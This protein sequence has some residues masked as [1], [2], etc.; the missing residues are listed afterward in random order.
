MQEEAQKSQQKMMNRIR[1]RGKV[2]EVQGTF[3]SWDHTFQKFLLEIKR[4]SGTSDIIPVVCKDDVSWMV[5]PGKE[6][7]VEGSVRTRNVAEGEHNKLE[8]TVFGFVSL[9]EPDEGVEEGALTDFNEVELDGFICK[10]VVLRETPFKKQIADIFIAVNGQANRSYY[11]PCVAFFNEAR[12]AS[13]LAVGQK[14][15]VKGRLQSRIYN[16]KI[17]ETEI[18]AKTAYEVVLSNIDEIKEETVDGDNN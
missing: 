13:K 18:V 5:Q 17:S 9:P 15:R 6:I 2:K 1:L 8:I 14:I 16:K 7:I 4:L 11:I 10:P 3:E 12:K